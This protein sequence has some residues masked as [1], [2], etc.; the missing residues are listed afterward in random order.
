MMSDAAICSSDT[1][2]MPA[3]LA[4]A[5]VASLRPASEVRTSM[6]FSARRPPTPLPIMPGAITATIGCMAWPSG[7]VRQVFCTLRRKAR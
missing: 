2:I 4:R 1:P 7:F 5:K 6:P 3:A